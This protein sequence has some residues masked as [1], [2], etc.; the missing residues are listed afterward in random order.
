M[1]KA[2]KLKYELETV[3]EIQPVSLKASDWKKSRTIVLLLSK[4]TQTDK[5]IFH[6]ICRKLFYC[7]A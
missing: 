4:F 1:E 6:F 7:I 3:Q 5:G 2:E